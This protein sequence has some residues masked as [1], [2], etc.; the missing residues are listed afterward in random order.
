MQAGERIRR[1]YVPEFKWRGPYNMQILEF[2]NGSQ[3]LASDR[4]RKS[5][6]GPLNRFQE[7]LTEL[8]IK[9]NDVQPRH[10]MQFAERVK[11]TINYR[12][13]KRGVSDSTVQLNLAAVSSYYAWCVETEQSEWNPVKGLKFKRT[14]R[15]R[16][17]PPIA[18]AVYA[19]N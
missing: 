14:E 4:T 12:T 16:M 8:G 19:S 10:I 5:Y 18:P 9:V 17:V 2:L 7:F 11:Q 13:G 1:E 3:K 6:H 15:P